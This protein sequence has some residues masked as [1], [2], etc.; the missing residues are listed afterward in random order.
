MHTVKSKEFIAL[1]LE[2]QRDGELEVTGCDHLSEETLLK[3]EQTLDNELTQLNMNSMNG[4]T[5]TS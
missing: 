1:L 2:E 5:S 3:V 4:K